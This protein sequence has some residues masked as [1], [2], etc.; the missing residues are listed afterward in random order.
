M[1]LW[2]CVRPCVILVLFN[3]ST[4]TGAKTQ[5]YMYVWSFHIILCQYRCQFISD[6]IFF[7]LWRRNSRTNEA[8]VTEQTATSIL[9]FYIWIRYMSARL[10]WLLNQYADTNT[11]DTTTCWKFDIYI[12][13]P[14]LSGVSFFAMSPTLNTNIFFK[15]HFI[16]MLPKLEFSESKCE[17]YIVCRTS[18]NVA[19]SL[20]IMAR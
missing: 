7:C 9:S 3:V 5:M 2:P 10:V 12:S 8:F 15:L 17:E 11:S 4:R 14:C 18:C 13:S 20:P 16:K 19:I 1:C 6:Y